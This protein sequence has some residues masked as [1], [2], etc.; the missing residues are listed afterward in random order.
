MSKDYLNYIA[1]KQ[2]G[3]YAWILSD[4]RM[5]MLYEYYCDEMSIPYNQ[6]YIYM[7]NDFEK[8]LQVDKE[9]R[10]AFVRTLKINNILS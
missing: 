8:Y 7:D 9:N 10:E 4:S 2:Y 1:A 5:D 3:V 6:K